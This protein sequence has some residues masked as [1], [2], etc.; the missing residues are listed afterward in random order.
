MPKTKEKTKKAAKV[1]ENGAAPVAKRR[2]AVK[3]EKQVRKNR[4]FVAVTSGGKEFEIPNIKSISSIKVSKSFKA[5]GNLQITS[6][7]GDGVRTQWQFN[8]K[9]GSLFAVRST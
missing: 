6:E 8:P 4:S 1:A 3:G 9:S 5:K 2:G 7:D